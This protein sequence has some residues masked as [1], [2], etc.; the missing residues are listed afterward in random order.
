M[1]IKKRR[2]GRPATFDGRTRWRLSKLIQKHGARG[3]K[4][5]CPFSI[6][7]QTLLKIA[8]EYDIPLEK[9][10]RPKKAA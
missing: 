3:A 6:S 2:R 10:R 8:R 9:G 1:G 5:A 4:E 7:V